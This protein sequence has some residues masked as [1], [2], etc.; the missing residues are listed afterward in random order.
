MSKAQQLDVLSHTFVM[1]L[2]NQ[3]NDSRGLSAL[4]DNVGQREAKRLHQEDD[5]QDQ[6]F[7]HDDDLL[8]DF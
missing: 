3:G 1:A 6:L 2:Q 4:L 8:A 7:Q 5:A